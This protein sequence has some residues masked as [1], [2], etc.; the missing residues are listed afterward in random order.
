MRAMRK[1]NQVMAVGL[2]VLFGAAGVHPA[3]WAKKPKP[4]ESKP[5]APAIGDAMQIQGTAGEMDTAQVEKLFREHQ[6]E[7]RHCYEE[8]AG[9]L[10]YVGGRMQV[11]VQVLP[12]GQI[13]S[14]TIP[15]SNLGCREVERCVAGVIEK[16]HFPA[17]KGGEGEVTYPFECA[18]RTRVGSWPG[19]R[20][21]S[22]IE[23]RRTALNGCKG[24][25]GSATVSAL[26][27]T[28]YVGPGGKATSVGFSAD[29]PLDEKLTSCVSKQLLGVQYD[30][31]LG[32]M[33]KV[34][35]DLGNLQTP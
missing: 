15:E 25:A 3:S 27:T 1:T 34:T 23:K 14:V 21:A 24:K 18:A 9:Q 2:M 33:V 11:K 6:P 5:P 19:E 29:A 7:L 20:V 13:K 12:T 8:I 30:D 16:L 32:Q 26:H 4:G 35:F 28:L 22:Q 17:P 10:H 31:P